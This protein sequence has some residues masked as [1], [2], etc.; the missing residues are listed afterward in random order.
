[1]QQLEVAGRLWDDLLSGR[2]TNTIRWREPRV[3]PGPLNFV[4]SDDPAQQAVVVVERCSDLPLGEVAV[5]LGKDDVW[6]ADVML[7]GMRSHYPDITMDDTVQVIEFAPV[8]DAQ[9]QR[10]PATTSSEPVIPNS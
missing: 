6:P 8:K 5:F 7:S 10:S 9:V 1:M 4:R 2:K 3:A